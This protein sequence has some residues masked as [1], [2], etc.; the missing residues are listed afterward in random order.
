MEDLEQNGDASGT[1]TGITVP[2]ELV[3]V[4]CLDILQDAVLVFCCAASCC[5]ECIRSALIDSDEHECPLCHTKD[6]SPDTL[7]PCI[8]LR[9]HV[10][11]FL[12]ESNPLW[13]KTTIQSP[14]HPSSSSPSSQG[15][16]IND[17]QDNLQEVKTPSHETQEGSSSTPGKK[18]PSSSSQG[19]PFKTDS[20]ALN[21]G[22]SPQN[23]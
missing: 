19:T 14:L 7:I 13:Q 6:V 12:N 21:K 23:T 15:I 8:K 4:L 5:D 10:V 1:S 22:S 11:S 17:D 2:E 20:P 18:S 16:V 3:C 9:R